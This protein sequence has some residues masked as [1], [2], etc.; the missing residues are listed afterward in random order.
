MK[1]DPEVL[2][3]PAFF[4]AHLPFLKKL[5][6][7]YLGKHRVV[8]L[9]DSHSERASGIVCFTCSAYFTNVNL[10]KIRHGH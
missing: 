4:S 3:P 5:T 9:C 1:R 7:E 10:L 8:S 6:E 2:I